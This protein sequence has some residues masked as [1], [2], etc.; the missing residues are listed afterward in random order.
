MTIFSVL[1]LKTKYT[2]CSHVDFVYLP[3][4]IGLP[5]YAICSQT[6]S[7]YST[8]HKILFIP[9]FFIYLNQSES[10]IHCI[11]KIVYYHYL[12]IHVATSHVV[13]C[14]RLYSGK[15]PISEHHIPCHVR[16]HIQ[17]NDQSAK[18]Q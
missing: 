15:R 5:Y 7:F 16:R 18:S 13:S 8:L 9:S 11:G 2:Y 12:A 6:K 10:Y 17:S 14:Q 3:F 1:Q 4:S